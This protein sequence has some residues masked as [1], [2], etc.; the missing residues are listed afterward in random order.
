MDILDILL[1][2]PPFQITETPVGPPEAI[3]DLAATPGVGKLTFTWT[4]P[5]NGGAAIEKYTLYLNGVVSQDFIT[6]PFEKTGLDPGVEIGEWT[7]TATNSEGESDPSNAVTAT[8]LSATVRGR[9]R[10]LLGV[11]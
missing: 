4:P 10:L 5:A 1:L 3:D 6:S 11:G 2:S 9:A 7:V 8:P